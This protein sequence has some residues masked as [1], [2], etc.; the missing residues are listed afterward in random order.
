M[1]TPQPTLQQ[2]HDLEVAGGIEW[3]FD[4][5]WRV[6]VGNPLRDEAMVGSEAEAMEWLAAKAQELYDV[7]A[8]EEPAIHLSPEELLRLQ[9]EKNRHMCSVL[10]GLTDRDGKGGR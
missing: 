3:T 10:D 4:G 1:T 5:S 8:D 2:L 9:R 7:D 6:W